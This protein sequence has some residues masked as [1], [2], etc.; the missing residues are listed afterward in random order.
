MRVVLEPNNKCKIRYQIKIYVEHIKL[1]KEGIFYKGINI[2]A[3][4]IERNNEYFVIGTGDTADEAYE[5][6][7]YRRFIIEN[8]I[9]GF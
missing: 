6:A 8:I 4:T 7:I 5:D 2:V 3:E 1:T 9:K